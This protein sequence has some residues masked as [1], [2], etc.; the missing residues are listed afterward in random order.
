[1][2]RGGPGGPEIGR[3]SV[4]VVPD[5]SRFR[6]EAREEIRRATAD[7][8]ADVELSV[9]ATGL[10]R[11]LRDTVRL[12]AQGITAQIRVE[13][14]PSV[15]VLRAELMLLI[16]RAQAGLDVEIPVR[17]NSRG[18][19]GFGGGGM[20][21][22]TLLL[23]G[24]IAAIIA[25]VVALV[26]TLLAALP[27]LVGM[28]GALAGV[29]YLGMDGIKRSFESLTPV[30]DRM[31]SQVSA[32][33]EKGLKPVVQD[34][35]QILPRLMPGINS[36]VSGITGFAKSITGVLNTAQGIQTI[37]TILQ[38]TGNFMKQIQPAAEAGTRAFM[39][40][41]LAGS[42]SFDV[43]GDSINR[44]AINF[45]NM[46]NRLNES[47]AI[48]KAIESLAP[49]VDALGDAF[50]RI[51][52]VGIQFMPMLSGP[53]ATF[54]NG[55]TDLFV[56]LMPILTAFSDLVLTLVGQLGSVLGPV[57]AALGPPIQRFVD[58]LQRG[59]QPL[60]PIIADLLMNVADVLAPLLD[61]LGPVVEQFGQA[62]VPVLQNMQPVI[63][64]IGAVLSEHLTGAIV[65]LAPLIP[66]L[67]QAFGELVNALMPLVPVILEAAIVVLPLL[68]DCINVAVIP[69]LQLMAGFFRDVVAPAIEWFAG[70][71][72]QGIEIAKTQF[73]AMSDHIR[74]AIATTEGIIN[75]FRDLP[76]NM[77][78]WM[79][80]VVRW[81]RTKWDE[82]VNFFREIPGKIRSALGDLGNLLVE[83]GKSIING[84]LNGLKSAWENV[85]SF[86]GGIAGWISANKGPV[87]YDRRLLRRHGRAIMEGFNYGLEKEY[88]Q[89][90]IT[91]QD[92]TKDIIWAFRPTNV[93]QQFAE[94]LVGGVPDALRSIDRLSSVTATAFRSD[95]TAAVETDDFGSI[96]DRVAEALSGWQVQ[97]D[98]NGLA[99][100][101]NRS[102]LRKARRG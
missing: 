87:S 45:E 70:V 82:V 68:V 36:V 2:A 96:S 94:S 69:V 48:T 27:S 86:V 52:E 101:V 35:A 41:A 14:V 20:G 21:A 13:W 99:K 28:F 38:N 30:L 67:V 93:G 80:E 77:A 3:V 88:K 83:A 102:N 89:V 5:V 29:V 6:R 97:L 63:R 95:F 19:G 37:N 42:S 54:I 71:I 58:A 76:Q 39:T 47:G 74:S 66:T 84:L 51:M 12:A 44:Y 40:L 17:F 59:L 18:L 90:K 60:L 91:I 7:L 49:V 4:R 85:K 16:R 34:I 10:R 11:Q 9:D 43:L 57:F 15:Q 53:L 32:A 81:I 22:S 1:M 79:T 33:F 92:I 73:N 26:A 24:A 50:I 64:D 75:F 23:A 25:P 8:K 56:G 46:V 78:Q 62:L 98:Q 31:K 72:K 100:L 61:V 55:F 65:A